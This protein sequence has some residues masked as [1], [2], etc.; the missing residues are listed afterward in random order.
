MG[1][2]L[3]AST[4]SRHGATARLPAQPLHLGAFTA[5]P[6]EPWIVVGAVLVVVF[7]TP[8]LCLVGLVAFYV[9]AL[10]RAGRRRSLPPLPR[11][12]PTSQPQPIIVGEVVFDD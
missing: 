1:I 7:G 8:L 6:K 10:T 11:P 5:D 4:F 9:W 3:S 12:A 2:A